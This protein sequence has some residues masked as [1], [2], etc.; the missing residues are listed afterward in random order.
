MAKTNVTKTTAP[1]GYAAAGSAVTMAAVDA[2]DGGQF[3]AQGKD[4]LVIRNSGATSHTYTVSSTADPFG[5]TKDLTGITIA[6]GAIHVVG[7]LPLD[8]WVQS[9]G[10]IYV[11]A[12]STEVLFGVVTLS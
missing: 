12:N 8:G 2:V 10:K 5:R 3:S 1:G 6:A 11:A 4:L 9:D 7:P